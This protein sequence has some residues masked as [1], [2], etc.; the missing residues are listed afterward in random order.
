MPILRPGARFLS[1]FL[2]TAV[3]F[4]SRANPEPKRPGKEVLRYF[5]G[6]FQSFGH[7][8]L[9]SKNTWKVKLLF[10]RLWAALGRPEARILDACAVDLMSRLLHKVANLSDCGS[11][12]ETLLEAWGQLF[13]VCCEV[14]CRSYGNR[15]KSPQLM[16]EP[17]QVKAESLSKRQVI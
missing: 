11:V 5:G 1:D 15:C 7:Q 10:E 13:G 9:A 4:E 17:S 3:H 6:H 16:R 8:K 12:L 2:N 14:L